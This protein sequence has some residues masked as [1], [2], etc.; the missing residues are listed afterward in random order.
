MAS[1]H[2]EQKEVCSLYPHRT[3]GDGSC[4]EMATEI[5]R[6]AQHKEDINL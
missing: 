3:V 1:C 5:M 4:I 6:V 2:T